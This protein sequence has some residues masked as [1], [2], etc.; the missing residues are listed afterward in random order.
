MSSFILKLYDKILT[1][2]LYVYLTKF[3]PAEQHGF[4]KSSGTMTNLFDSANFI[5]E[6][7]QNGNQVD[8]IYFDFSKAFDMI[9]HSII[10]R[11]LAESSTPQMIFMAI[12]MFVINRT[13]T[14][15]ISNRTTDLQSKAT[16]GVPQ[17]SHIGP[18]LFIFY[19]SDV[20]NR[21]NH[22]SL[23][24]LLFADDTKILCVIK[25]LIDSILLQK[26]IDAL[27]TW[28]M[29][30]CLPLNHAKTKCVSYSKGKRLKFDTTY[31]IDTTPIER[32]NT[33]TDLGVIFDNGLTFKD[34][35]HY[36]I[37]RANKILAVSNKLA[38]DLK[39][40]SLLHV[41]FR[42]YLLPVIENCCPVW[43]NANDQIGKY[44]T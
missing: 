8:V 15:E 43:M 9:S 44:S 10:A 25:Q 14:L 40:P 16:R 19:S 18:L 6:N 38:K 36:L 26:A 30:N 31:F 34:H 29:A 13:Y 23:V 32:T 11:K 41:L 4:V 12:M 7:I 20:L 5:A 17:G 33:H 27:N 35:L 39:C 22:P 2:K 21:I 37:N 3:V 28:S 42:T 1:E 24:A